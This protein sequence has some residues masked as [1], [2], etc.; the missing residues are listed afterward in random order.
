LPI[1][2][3]LFVREWGESTVEEEGEPMP[4][5]LHGIVPDIIIITQTDRLTFFSIQ[6]RTVPGCQETENT[7]EKREDLSLRSSP[8]YLAERPDA[9]VLS[10]NE[11]AY[12]H[13]SL[14]HG[15]VV[16]VGRP[17]KAQEE[18]WNWVPDCSRTRRTPVSTTTHLRRCPAPCVWVGCC[19]A[20]DAC[21]RNRPHRCP[22][23]T[24]LFQRAEKS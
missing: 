17:A 2:S 7:P 4:P 8:S 21:R 18:R 10:Q 20:C 15:A 5:S 11:L 14:L 24:T 1:V 19:A 12:L 22:V 13:W 23:L 16:V 9:K 3:S 6:R